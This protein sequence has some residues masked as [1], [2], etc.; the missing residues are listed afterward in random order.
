VVGTKFEIADPDNPTAAEEVLLQNN[1]IGLSAIHETLDE[2][3]FQQ[4]KGLR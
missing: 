2:K 3:T 4:M 1:D